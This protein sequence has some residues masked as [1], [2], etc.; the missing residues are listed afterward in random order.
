MAKKRR[1]LVDPVEELRENLRIDK[2]ALD[3]E[4]ELQPVYL[5]RAHSLW[6]EAKKKRDLAREEQRRVDGELYEIYAKELEKENKKKPTNAQID[7]QLNQDEDHIAAREEYKDAQVKADELEGITEAFKQR[8][9]LLRD[10]VQLHV[11]N[12]YDTNSVEHDEQ[13]ARQRAR[14]K[15]EGKKK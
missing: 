3:E 12:Y 4:I 11:V 6:A 9:F 2:H 10:L 1:K 13:E 14:A 7:A 8:G 5:D 15:R